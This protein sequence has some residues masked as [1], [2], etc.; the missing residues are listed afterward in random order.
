MASADTQL[1][2]EA[3]EEAVQSFLDE[4]N[5]LLLREADRPAVYWL[6][7]RPKSAPHETY[8]ARVAW[9]AYPDRPPS[10]RFHDHIGGTFATNRAWPIVPGYRV[11]SW[12]ICKPLT[13]EGY[14][15]H[16]EWQT[17]PHAWKSAGNPFLWV[18]HSLQNDLNH[19]YQGRNS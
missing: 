12:D 2:L 9:T 14:A 4:W 10:V 13:A 3:D 8:Y 18:A 1:T 11:G 15:L 17:G 16:G 19:N 6:V 5:G 7:L